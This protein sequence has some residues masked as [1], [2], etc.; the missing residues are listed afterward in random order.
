MAESSTGL[1][2]LKPAGDRFLVGIVAGAVL[3]AL[4]AVVV[5]FVGRPVA[6]SSA[7]A[8]D[9][10]SP[11]GVV[12]A[13]AE[14]V[15][16]GDF[17]RAYTYLSRSAQSATSLAAYRQRYGFP[18]PAGS[19]ARLVIQPIKVEADSAEVRVTVSRFYAN[20]TPFS[21]STSRNEVTVRLVRED[22]AW[23]IDQPIEPYWLR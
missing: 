1:R 17:D 2:P 7:A 10:G 20:P 5:V 6:G 8:A 13:Y 23:R 9:P 4:A 22:G 15:R 12:Q 14:A 19:E 21:P 18:G 11:A 3:L 16:E